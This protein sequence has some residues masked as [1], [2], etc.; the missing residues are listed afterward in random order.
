MNNLTD[1]QEEGEQPLNK[2][3][4]RKAEENEKSITYIYDRRERSMTY[5]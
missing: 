1:D 3:K 5:E 4:E 2:L